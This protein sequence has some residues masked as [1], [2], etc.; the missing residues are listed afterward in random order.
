MNTR[1]TPD[2]PLGE[3]LLM[4]V[5][6]R[7]EPIVSTKQ[8]LRQ[9]CRHNIPVIN[10]LSRVTIADLVQSIV[11][12]KRERSVC[13][14]RIEAHRPYAYIA[15]RMGLRPAPDYCIPTREIL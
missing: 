1:L 15:E 7:H 9:V 13:L 11:K 6:L 3:E 4:F 12:T 5:L 2:Y 10:K 8:I 14:N